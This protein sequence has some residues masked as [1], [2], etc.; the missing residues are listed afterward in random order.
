[1]YSGK[2][3]KC[4]QLARKY[5]FPT[6]NINNTF[7]LQDYGIFFGKI[8]FNELL[9]Y[10]IIYIT[11]DVIEAHI[12]DV[13]KAIDKNID[14]PSYDDIIDICIYFK[15]RETIKYDCLDT[16]INDIHKD[17]LIAEAFAIIMKEYSSDTYKKGFI[18]YSGGKE[19][20]III[21]MLDRLKLLENIDI[22][23]FKPENLSMCKEQLEYMD[24]FLK[25]YNKSYSIL[26]YDS[27]L[28]KESIH[29][30]EEK[31][32]YSHCFL[33]FRETDGNIGKSWYSKLVMPLYN[34]KY[35]DIWHYIDLFNIN[36]SPL[37]SKGFTSVGYNKTE[38]ELLLCYSSQT[39]RHAKFLKT[40]LYWE[41]ESYT[42]NR[43]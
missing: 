5:G 17:I 18:A 13:N 30:F 26:E 4:K 24:D 10:S 15:Q 34:F 14:I 38:N 43:Y 6:L 39:Y 1:M 35:Q 8:I 33:G 12:L 19:S 40:V 9:Y 3:V 11:K 37:Y 20:I 32:N 2:V 7:R 22:V 41:Q 31:N 36:A 21:D 29:E 42:I 16:C 27:N 28:Y 23:H 25:Q